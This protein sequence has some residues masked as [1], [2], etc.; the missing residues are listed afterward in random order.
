MTISVAPVKMVSYDIKIDRTQNNNEIS[1]ENLVKVGYL[2][3]R[4]GV[5]L[6]G[7]PD[8]ENLPKFDKNNLNVSINE[9]TKDYFESNLNKIGIKFNEIA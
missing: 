1:R 9:C 5:N 2:A 8:T 6:N 3:G 7:N 4:C